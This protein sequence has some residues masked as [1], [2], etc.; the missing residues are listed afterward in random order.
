MILPDS[1]PAFYIQMTGINE[2]KLILAYYVFLYDFIYKD[3]CREGVTGSG[4]NTAKP[5]L[6]GVI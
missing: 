2:P 6:W 4:R 3:L 5:Q 1:D